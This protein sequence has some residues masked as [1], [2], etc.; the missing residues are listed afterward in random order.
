MDKTIVELFAGV[1]GFRL[2]F[3]RQ[4]SAW[5]TVWANQWE[6]STKNQFAFDCYKKHFENK[7]GINEYSNTN[8]SLVSEDNIPN[9]TLLVGGFPCQ[10]YSVAA[11]NAKGIEGEKGVLWWEIERIVKCKKPSFILLENVDRLLKSPAKQKGR[12]FGIMLA[13]LNN[14]GYGVEWRVINAAEY[15]LQQR[16][17][18]VFIFA[19]RNTTKYF[20]N[21]LLGTFFKDKFPIINHEDTKKSI[22]LSD[23]LVDITKNF[24]FIFENSGC[25]IDGTITT[26]KC[27]PIHSGKEA[28]LFDILEDNVD[29]KYIL[30][31]E[32][33]NKI[34][35]LKSHK[36]KERISKTGFKYTYSEGAVPFPD[37]LDRPA[38]TMLTSES[39]ANRSTHVVQDKSSG[40]LRVL[41]PVECERI[42]GFDDNWTNTGMTEKYRYFC[43]GNALVVNLIT[44]M[45]ETI[46]KIID[47]E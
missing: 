5:K 28:R 9:H 29:K 37:I 19:F 25:M 10:N 30:T 2:G 39:S 46:E 22:R 16:R 45:A 18:R 8:V 6:P 42:N 26:V 3:E 44:M 20:K 11:T 38:R 15:G 24:Q 31:D 33:Y 14:L 13:C 34:K 35:Y 1:G 32:K 21:Y 41:T 12:D 17:R 27:T 43:M 4:S 40:K 7:G 36:T 47:A 23:D